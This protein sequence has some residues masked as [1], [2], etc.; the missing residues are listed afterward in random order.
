MSDT[1]L[2]FLIISEDLSITYSI[3]YQEKYLYVIPEGWVIIFYKNNN[4]S[5]ICSLHGP[6][7]K[8]VKQKLWA[9]IV[10][11]YLSII[12]PVQY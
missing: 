10:W 2:I 12:A 3:F 5:L 7:A 6:Y 4:K 8:Y 1:L 11:I 9:Y